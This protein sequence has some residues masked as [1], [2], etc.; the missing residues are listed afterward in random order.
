M[1]PRRKS[2]MSKLDKIA[3]SE[4]IDVNISSGLC[5][6]EFQN[7]FKTSSPYLLHRS[8]VVSHIC[9]L[10][11]V[12]HLTHTTQVRSRIWKTFRN[13]P[14]YGSRVIPRMYIYRHYLEI[15][16]VISPLMHFQEDF[17]VQIFATRRKIQVRVFDLHFLACFEAARVTPR[18]RWQPHK[19]Y[20]HTVRMW[21]ST[22][23]YS[24]SFFSTW[25]KTLLT[26]IWNFW[27]RQFLKF[28]EWIRKW[29]FLR[30]IWKIF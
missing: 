19:F 15:F 30:D 24:I 17:A 11:F 29:N 22:F 26:D 7:V 28:A 18:V 23:F 1:G 6:G 8:Y 21:I 10:K 9:F 27:S 20:S 12:S 14:R 3:I 13:W 2:E 4:S 25:N 5:V 16:R